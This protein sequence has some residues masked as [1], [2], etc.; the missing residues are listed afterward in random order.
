MSAHR[1]IA[2]LN[3][4]VTLR[5]QQ[6][7]MLVILVLLLILPLQFDEHIVKNPPEAHDYEQESGAGE[8]RV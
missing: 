6:M 1:P 3:N 8:E 4:E 2:Y 5:T 7:A